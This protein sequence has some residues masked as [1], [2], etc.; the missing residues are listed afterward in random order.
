MSARTVERGIVLMVALIVMV[1]MSLAGVALVRAI[2]TSTI[3]GGNL[4]SREAALLALDNGIERAVAALYEQN[5]I[6][7]RDHD[8][9]AA[10]YFASRQQGEDARGVPL[11]L[12]QRERYPR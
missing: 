1:A 11:V 6:A 4:V 12:Q 10:S 3:V 8:L 7:D 5:A 9:V 2:D